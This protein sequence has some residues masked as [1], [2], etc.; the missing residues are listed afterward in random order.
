MVKTSASQA[1]I[2][3]STPSSAISIFHGVA[4]GFKNFDVA[5]FLM[6]NVALYFVINWKHYK[7][8]SGQ[9]NGI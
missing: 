7:Y 1:E 9:Y 8:A 2:E 6:K 4:S 3:G 5:P